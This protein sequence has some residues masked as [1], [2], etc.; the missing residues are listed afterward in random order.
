LLPT[1]DTLASGIDWHPFW[2][3]INTPESRSLWYRII[4][5][6]VYCQKSIALCR[7]DTS[8]QCPFCHH[9][10]ETI[11]HLLFECPTKV[12]IWRIVL[13]FFAP[14]L[15]FEHHDIH[16]R[17]YQ[18]KSF[19]HVNNYPASHMGLQ[20]VTSYSSHWRLVF[21]GKP[22]LPLAIINSTL[23]IHSRLQS[24]ISLLNY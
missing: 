17:I 6:K 8:D 18:L 7:T 21:D 9:V 13:S 23:K 4:H 14:H 12:P 20:D 24:E 16:Q 1:T 11:P 19:D 15:F 2:A 10:V 3:L 22:L 5:G